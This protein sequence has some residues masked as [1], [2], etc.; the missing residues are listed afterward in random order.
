MEEIYDPDIECIERNS[1]RYPKR[2]REQKGMPGKLYV[3]GVLP[4]DDLPTA[5]V[6]GARRC[7]TYGSRQAFFFA[8]ELSRAGVQ[9]I[10]GLALGIDG[11]AHSGALEGGTA[12]FAVLGSGV[13]VC[14]PRQHQDLYRQVWQ[15]GGLISEQPPGTRPLGCYFPARNRIISAL[16]DVVLVIEAR[17][18]SGS[19]ITVDF[20]LEQGKT[21]YAL[22]GPVDSSL[23]L[24]CHR[25][26]EQG[27]G[28]A[29]SVQTVLSEWGLVEKQKERSP[30]KSHL[31]LARDLDLVYSC[32][33]LRPKSLQ[34]IIEETR[35][36][37]KKVLNS[38]TELELEGLVGRIG[39]KFYQTGGDPQAGF[40]QKR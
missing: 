12:T 34:E 25:L 16:S 19:L 13:D 21:V 20:A 22:P 3:R 1:S 36:P 6:V 9:V 27:A 29:W 4:R 15:S 26:L 39:Q 18:K 17:E 8:K 2:L 24:G 32:L 31:R 5:A 28:V 11:R 33:D 37:A 10:S 35:F 23:S 38:L 14:Y 40:A 30:K 7:S